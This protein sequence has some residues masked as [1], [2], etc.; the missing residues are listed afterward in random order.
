MITTDELAIIKSK[1][2]QEISKMKKQI[3]DLKSTIPTLKFVKQV[4]EEESRFYVSQKHKQEKNIG[5][6]K[7]EI[8]L[9]AK[10]N[11]SQ[12]IGAYNILR[13]FFDQSK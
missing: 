2:Q 11:A 12:H 13:S 3:K 9:Q 8:K 4:F 6:S 5:N 7:A 10:V 1:M